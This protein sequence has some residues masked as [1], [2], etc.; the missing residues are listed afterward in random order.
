MQPSSMWVLLDDLAAHH[1]DGADVAA[2]AGDDALHQVERVRLAFLDGDQLARLRARA[3]AAG[4]KGLHRVHRAREQ[5]GRPR[6]RCQ[7]SLN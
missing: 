7:V 5:S 6:H 4:I 3:A 2:P 1:A